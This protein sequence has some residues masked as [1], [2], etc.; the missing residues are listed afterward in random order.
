MTTLRREVL[1]KVLKL[2]DLVLMAGSFFLTTVFIVRGSGAMTLSEFLSMRIKVENFVLFF[3]LLA[4][5]HVI[6]SAFGLYNSRRMSG[7]TADAIDT[8][9]ATTAGTLLV[10]VAA[11]AF[12]IRM[13]SPVFLL[14]FWATATAIA[15][16]LR[17]LQR[18]VLERIRLRGRNL[19]N[20]PI[21]SEQEFVR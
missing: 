3:A 13:L 5:W 14:G 21:G 2:F 4:L 7:R 16:T 19:R 10:A 8:F 15:I 9:G 18:S 6:F 17:L 12:R 1:L 11:L 20:M